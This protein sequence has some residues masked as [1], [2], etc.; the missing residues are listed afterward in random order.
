MSQKIQ[1]RTEAD[2]DTSAIVAGPWPSELRHDVLSFSRALYEDGVKHAL[3]PMERSV[4]IP[5]DSLS[6]EQIRDVVARCAELVSPL[7]YQD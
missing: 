2:D 1:V 3:D 6:F 7:R 5:L 4:R